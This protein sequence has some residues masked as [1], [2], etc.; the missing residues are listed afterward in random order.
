MH[1]RLK[2]EGGTGQSILNRKD[3]RHWGFI[4]QHYMGDG[5]LERMNYENFERR[6]LIDCV[7]VLS[8]IGI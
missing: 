2:T 8:I 3:E 1:F 6:I 4:H 7:T 5:G